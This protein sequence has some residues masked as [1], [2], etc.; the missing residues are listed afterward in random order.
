MLFSSAKDLKL[1]PIAGFVIL[2]LFI[3]LSCERPE[4]IELV[5]GDCPAGSLKSGD[6]CLVSVGTGCNGSDDCIGGFCMYNYGERYCTQR[7]EEDYDCPPGYFCS[8][9]GSDKL[10]IKSIYSRTV[11]SNDKEC[12]PCGLCIN[13]LC[14]LST[15]C[16]VTLC[17]DDSDC[18][19]CRRCVDGRCIPIERCGRGCNSNMDCDKNQICDRDYQGRL[20]CIPR[21][22]SETGMYCEGEEP[23]KECAGGL[24]LKADGYAYSYCSRLCKTDSDCP[25]DF[26]CGIFP[27]YPDK[28]VCIKKG[29]YEP[30][31]CNNSKDCN[32]GLKCRYAFSDDKSSIATFCGILNNGAISRDYCDTSYE[33]R[34]GM[35]GRLKYC[36][37]SC[38][39]ICT[40]PCLMDYDCPE[41]FVCEELLSSENDILYRGCVNYK[42]V[43]KETGEYC[44]YSNEE[45]K[46]SI[47]VKN[48]DLPYC[49]EICKST[50]DC[51]ENFVCDFY[52]NEQLCLMELSDDGCNRDGDCT[53]GLFCSLIDSDGQGRVQC[54]R[55]DTDSALPGEICDRPCSSGIC[56]FEYNRCS[57]FCVDKSDCPDGY[58]CAFFT[59]NVGF[60]MDIIKKLC[61]P[62][63]GSL[64]QC[65]RDEGCPEGEVC[66]ISFDKRSGEA[67]PLCMKVYTELK[68]YGDECSSN[69]ECES[70]VCLPDKDT[71]A[72]INYIGKCT[73]FCAI[74]SDCS[75][76]DICRIVPFYLSRDYA[77]AVRVCA[78]K[79]A[80]ADVGQSCSNNP[81]VCDSGLCAN[82]DEKN[83]FCTERCRDHF[84]CTKSLTVCRL[85][86]K[87]GT[88]CL[89]VTY[90]QEE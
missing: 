74:D 4:R 63:P 47:C 27:T 69:E 10:C 48:S 52:E 45:C 49:S 78:R 33:C 5:R 31:R 39:N 50:L 40:M 80:D 88:I 56:L 18:G 76:P 62:H 28:N 11:C 6:Y 68:K 43:K 85:I 72:S 71:D 26:Y 35:C 24:C 9:A 19:S 53:D 83:S 55:S 22:P 20:A 2:S 13:N 1:I 84:D 82:V 61:I 38:R 36:K 58:I 81:Y 54:Y 70:G 66:R 30:R 77:K 25:Y 64:Y 90:F 17:K 41:G 59:L 23:Y 65:V 15:I 67:E 29:M 12:E 16:V 46:S 51:P 42:D 14:E 44:T 37:D 75:N 8:K 86:D 34:W 3:P 73:R 21:T 32:Y 60:N 79:P 89:P 7:C 57:A 87:I